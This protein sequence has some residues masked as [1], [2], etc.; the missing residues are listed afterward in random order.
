MLVLECVP[1]RLGTLIAEKLAIPVIGIGAGSGTDGQVLVFHDL[2]G[3]KA[4]FTPKFVK[5]YADVGEQMFRAVSQFCSDVRDRSFPTRDHS[6]SIPDEEYSA[7]Q[8]Q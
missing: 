4:G 2:V 8:T 1:D 7:L 3:I 5:R 6:F